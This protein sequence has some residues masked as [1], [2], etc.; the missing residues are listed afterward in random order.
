MARACVEDT[1]TVIAGNGAGNPNALALSVPL[2][3]AG[4]I[5]C[6]PGVGIGVSLPIS[7]DGVDCCDNILHRNPVSGAY[8]VPRPGIISVPIPDPGIVE[9]AYSASGTPANKSITSL[10]M[11]N[12]LPCDAIAMV[13]VN[14]HFKFTVAGSADSYFIR[15]IAFINASGVGVTGL[16]IDTDGVPGS[17]PVLTTYRDDDYGTTDAAGSNADVQ[18]QYQMTH[19]VKVPAGGTVTFDCL[20]NQFEESNTISANIRHSAFPTLTGN[21]SVEMAGHL[22]WYKYGADS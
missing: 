13:T 20:H 6:T 3:P 10:V 17:Q 2:D 1:C 19:A 7:V 22:E 21:P 15:P 5:T 4:G 9:L 14:V 12:P 18:K 11:A 8:Y 16:G